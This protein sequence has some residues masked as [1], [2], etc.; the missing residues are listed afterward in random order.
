MFHITSTS[1]ESVC[2]YFLVVGLLSRVYVDATKGSTDRWCG[3]SP[4]HPCKYLQRGVSRT[5]NGGTL[6]LSSTNVLRKTVHLYRDITITSEA[7]TATIEGCMGRTCKKGKKMYAFTLK[8]RLRFKLIHVHLGNI[9][10]FYAWRVG[11]SAISIISIK[12]SILV[13]I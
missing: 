9:G 10:I 6:Y 13:F 3:R 5:R 11:G 2:V 7:N 12:F 1:F 8:K 4:K